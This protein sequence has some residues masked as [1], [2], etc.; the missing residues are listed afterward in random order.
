MTMV[1]KTIV[2]AITCSDSIVGKA[3]SDSR[4]KLRERRFLKPCQEFYCQIHLE[5]SCFGAAQLSDQ[6][7]VYAI[8][9]PETAMATQSKS[10]MTASAVVSTPFGLLSHAA[11]FRRIER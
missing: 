1:P 11:E 8:H 4:I 10:V 7:H 6:C 2:S 9:R 5:P 3:H